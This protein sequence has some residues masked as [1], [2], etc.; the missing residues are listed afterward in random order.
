M[1]GKVKFVAKNDVMVNTNTHMSTLRRRAPV[2]AHAR[3]PAVVNVTLIKGIEG[4][5]HTYCVLWT[6]LWFIAEIRGMMENLSTVTSSHAGYK[7]M[8]DSHPVTHI[9]S[10]QPAQKHTRIFL[11]QRG[12]KI[13]NRCRKGHRLMCMMIST[14]HRVCNYCLTCQAGFHKTTNS[15]LGSWT[16]VIILGA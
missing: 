4:F 2:L 15:N 13:E 12:A 5:M 6:G 10:E 8:L 1:K 7:P 9:Y 3:F 16:T 14:Q 11:L